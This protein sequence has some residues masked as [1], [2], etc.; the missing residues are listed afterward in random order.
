[1]AF[2]VGILAINDYICTM[3]IIFDI[4]FLLPL[5]CGAWMVFLSF[6]KYEGKKVLNGWRRNANLILGFILIIFGGLLYCFYYKLG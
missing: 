4:F 5:I 1:M 6:S 3:D 2:G